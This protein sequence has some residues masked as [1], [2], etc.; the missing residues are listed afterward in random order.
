MKETGYSKYIYQNE[1][2][3]AC[4]QNHMPYI[5]CLLTAADRVLRDKAFNIAK[6]PNYDGYQRGLASK[7]FDKKTAGGAVKNQIM[8]NNELANELHKSIIRKAKS[9]FSFI[10]N[11]CG[12]IVMDKILYN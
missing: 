5:V 11:I 12:T 10:D 3:K 2:D 6:N 1:L 4:S 8:Q 7:S 9:A